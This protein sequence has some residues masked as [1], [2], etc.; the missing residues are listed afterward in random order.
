M[1]AYSCAGTC[2]LRKT[3]IHAIEG[4]FKLDT[5]SAVDVECLKTFPHLPIIIGE[6]Q[7][8][9]LMVRLRVTCR[10]HERRGL[11]HAIW[12]VRNSLHS[13]PRAD[14]RLHV[15]DVTVD[16]RATML[17]KLYV[18]CITVSRALSG[19]GGVLNAHSRI[20]R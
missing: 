9:A 8:R 19:G 18:G 4:S 13:R 12:R 11:N 1:G 16:E 2:E 15:N 5:E 7:W 14:R 3:E 17:P 6:F 20:F 10:R